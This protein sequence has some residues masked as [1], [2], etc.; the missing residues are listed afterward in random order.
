MEDRQAAVPQR[1]LCHTMMVLFSIP[2]LGIF[3]ASASQAAP[4]SAHCRQEEMQSPSGSTRLTQSATEALV[5]AP[6][7]GRSASRIDCDNAVVDSCNSGH[8][9]LSQASCSIMATSQEEDVGHAAT[10][11]GSFRERYR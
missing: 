4:A 9:E 8:S 5:A 3:A 1:K 10:F 11:P 2:N 7:C 6:D